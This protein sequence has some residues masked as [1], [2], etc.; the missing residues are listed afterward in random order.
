[1]VDVGQCWLRFDDLLRW[2][3]VGRRY[4][5]LVEIGTFFRCWLVDVL[6]CWLAF[7]S[8]YW[9]IACFT[10]AMQHSPSHAINSWLIDVDRF[11]AHEIVGTTAVILVADRFPAK[12]LTCLDFLMDM[13]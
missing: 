2:G 1:M 6:A 12:A 7:R 3:D 4:M 9:F 8:I 10:S 5:I 11:L 13:W